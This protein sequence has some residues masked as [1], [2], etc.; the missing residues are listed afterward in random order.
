MRIL[1]LVE[2]PEDVDVLAKRGPLDADR[3]LICLS[4]GAAARAEELGLPVRYPDQYVSS[5]QLQRAGA[6]HFE[7]IEELCGALDEVIRATIV[8]G[9]VSPRTFYKNL[10]VL[11]DTVT[12]R[13]LQLRAI[14]EV[15]CPDEVVYFETT[16]FGFDHRLA[17]DERESIYA[18]VIPHCSRATCPDARLARLDSAAVRNEPLL[19]RAKRTALSVRAWWCDRL[20]WLGHWRRRRDCSICVVETGYGLDEVLPDL[21]KRADLTFWRPPM[22][23]NIPFGTGVLWSLFAGARSR[24]ISAIGR[25]YADIWHAVDGSPALRPYLSYEGVDFYEVVRSR[26]RFLVADVLPRAAILLGECERYLRRRQDV[27]VVFSVNF[28]LDKPWTY[29]LAL[30]AKRRHVPVVTYQHSAFGYFYWPYSK[31]VDEVMSDYR[32]VWGTGSVRFMRECDRTACEPIVV[33]SEC[34][35]IPQPGARSHGR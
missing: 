1:V 6:N 19:R 12:L 14:F 15:E 4:P 32:L 10:K 21:A 28:S 18:Q 13:V 9:A 33:G 24:K 8:D 35:S 23:Q 5:E 17:F 30:A 31:Y 22:W 7:R 25:K 16:R 2:F 29:L 20:R 34:A 26:L 3:R 11:Y 27:R